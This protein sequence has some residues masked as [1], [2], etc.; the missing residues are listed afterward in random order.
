MIGMKPAIVA[1]GGIAGIVSALLL[2]RQGWQVTL[3]EREPECGGLLRSFRGECGTEFDYGPHILTDTGVPEL[4]ELLHGDLDPAHW[5]RLPF[6]RSGHVFAGRLY[7]DSPFPRLANLPRE[8]YERAV[9]EMLHRGAPDMEGCAN[10]GEYLEA[11]FGPTIAR[12]VFGPALEKFLGIGIDQL[13][14][15]AWRYFGLARVLAFD[16]DL[17]RE[18]KKSPLLDRKIGFHRSEGGTGSSAHY[19]PK[20]GGIGQWIELLLGKLRALGVELRTAASI[21]AIERQGGKAVAVTLEDGQRL[22]CDLLVWSINPALA[23]KALGMDRKLGAIPMRRS[24]LFYYVF[25]R[26]FATDTFYA[27]CLDP[28]FRTFRVTL[29]SNFRSEERDIAACCVETMGAAEQTEAPSLAEIEGELKT[30]G[31]ID[32]SARVRSQTTA[33]IREGFP[34]PT[35]GFYELAAEL[36]GEVTAAAENIAVVGKAAGKSFFTN[37]T[38]IA[39][40]RLLGGMRADP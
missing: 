38:L 18:F 10:C 21:R 22:P 37:D 34:V 27:Q 32:T 7:G 5:E 36:T 15:D 20:R 35:S 39:A 40:H 19:Y 33:T 1:G 2:A 25:D 13:A 29:F 14:P 17:T 24:R 8:D 11:M 16:A 4:D 28:G 3:I 26:P 9:I 6:L 31:F 12:R 30:M 23:L